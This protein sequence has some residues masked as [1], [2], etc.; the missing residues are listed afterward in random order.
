MVL[1]EWVCLVN[2][3]PQWAFIVYRITIKINWFHIEVVVGRVQEVS[4]YQP[5]IN[6]SFYTVE[7]VLMLVVESIFHFHLD[8]FVGKPQWGVAC[9]YYF[10]DAISILAY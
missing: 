4:I 9:N 1:V 2:G 5:H 3:T 7:N 6:N 8:Y 10:P